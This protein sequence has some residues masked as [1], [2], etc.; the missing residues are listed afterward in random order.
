MASTLPK[1]IGDA[2]VEPFQCQ[3]VFHICLSCTAFGNFLFHH[4]NDKLLIE[5]NL[6]E[7]LSA[8]YSDIIDVIRNT[9]FQP[10]T[11]FRFSLFWLLWEHLLIIVLCCPCNAI[12][13][14]FLFKTRKIQFSRKISFRDEK[15]LFILFV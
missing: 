4:W 7:R 13:A 2:F 8:F 11:F 10:S 14:Y 3:T 6:F 1:D 9:T 5:F 12:S 15:Y